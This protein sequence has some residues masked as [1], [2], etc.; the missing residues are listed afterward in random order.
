MRRVVITGMGAVTPLGCNVASFWDGII[1]SRSGIRL[2]AHFDA[3]K[4]DVLFG[5]DCRDFDASAHFD[6]RNIKRMDR[7]TQLALVAAREAFAHSGLKGA[8]FEPTRAGVIVG[9]GIGGIKELEDQ[10]KRLIEKGPSRVSAFTIPKLMANAC[11]GHISIDL[12]LQ[13]VNTTVATAC[14]SAGNAIGD[15][16]N[17]IRYD[18]ADIMVTGGTEAALTELGL[19]AF[20]AMKALSTRNDAPDK[21][22]RPFDKDRD[23]FVLSE[24]A[25]CIVLEEYEHAKKRGAKIYAELLGCAAT[26]DADDMVQPNPEGRGASRA[27][28]AALRCAKINPDGVDYISAHGTSTPLGDVAETTAIKNVFGAHARKLAIS[29]IKGAVGHTLGASGGLAVVTTLMGM[30]SNTIPPT[31]NLDQPDAA[32]DL[33][34]VPRTPRD[35]R[36]S[37]ALINSFGFGGHN[38]CV[39]IRKV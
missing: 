7:F 39:V 10:Y 16:F 13:A 29:S 35:G 25:G 9:A 3:S 8:A 23:G 33:D 20:A 37:T 36:L 19:A 28:V 6:V 1:T 4:F 26:A 17:T 5:G 18:D 38:A 15:A 32:C 34:Y 14:A 21:A 27:M 2:I 30:Q 31:L 11:A 12:G 22:S 24:G